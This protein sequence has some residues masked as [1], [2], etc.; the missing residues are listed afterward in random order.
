VSI[1]TKKLYEIEPRKHKRKNK[2]KQEQTKGDPSEKRLNIR[3]TGVN[4]KN[5]FTSVIYRIDFGK[6]LE[7]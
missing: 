2:Q 4:P 5:S 3:G 7:Q 1:V 6:V